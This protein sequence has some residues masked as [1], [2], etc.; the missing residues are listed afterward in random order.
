MALSHVFFLLLFNEMHLASV[1]FFT[2]GYIVYTTP[3]HFFESS[4]LCIKVF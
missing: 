2:N 4:Q 1:S 3:D